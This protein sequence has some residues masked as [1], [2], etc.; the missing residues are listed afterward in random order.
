VA[1]SSRRSNK[2]SGNISPLAQYEAK[3]I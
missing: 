2:G 3:F 1:R